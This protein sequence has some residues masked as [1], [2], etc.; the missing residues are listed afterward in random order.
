MSG[1]R[2]KEILDEIRKMNKKLDETGES[3]RVST[4]Q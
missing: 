4:T 1:E 3:N 2:E